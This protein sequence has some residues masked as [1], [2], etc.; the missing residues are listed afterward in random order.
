MYICNRICLLFSLYPSILY[1][2]KQNIFFKGGSLGCFV[3]SNL[4]WNSLHLTFFSR[5]HSETPSF[6]KP[7]LISLPGEKC[8]TC[9]VVSAPLFPCTIF[10]QYLGLSSTLI[11][12]PTCQILFKCE[13][14]EKGIVPYLFSAPRPGT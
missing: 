3:P 7:F 10:H 13:S 8:I 1:L 9:F 2:S 5:P 11:Y 14:F 6:V 4:F 12:F